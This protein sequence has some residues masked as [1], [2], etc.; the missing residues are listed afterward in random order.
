[1]RTA[2][3]THHLVYPNLANVLTPGALNQLWLSDITHIRLRREFSYLA[4]IIDAF[5]RRVIS[6]HPLRFDDGFNHPVTVSSL[7]GKGLRRLLERKAVGDQRLEL[8]SSVS[9]QL[10]GAR[11]NVPHAARELNR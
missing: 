8:H 7:Q 9:H 10:D 1:M 3:A 2:N 5:S 4:V 6:S 11:V